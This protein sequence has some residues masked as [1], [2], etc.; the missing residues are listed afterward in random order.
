MRSAA[1]DSVLLL[2]V[3]SAVNVSLDLKVYQDSFTCHCTPGYSG[4]QCELDIDECA[5]TPCL[6][7][8]TCADQINKFICQ[9]LEGFTGKS[10]RYS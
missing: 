1:V 4:R 6:N 8:A 3:L 2:F 7:N 5:D 10:S 9:C